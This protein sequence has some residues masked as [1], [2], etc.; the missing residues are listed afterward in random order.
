MAEIMYKGFNQDMTCRDFQYEVGGHYEEDKAELCHSGFHAC[1]YPLDC[2]NYYRP[3]TSEYCTVEMDGLDESKEDDI[4]GGQS[5][6][7][8]KKISIVRKLTLGEMIANSIYYVYTKFKDRFK[9]SKRDSDVC[10]GTFGSSAVVMKG[11][12]SVAACT[13]WSSVAHT[14]RIG[15]VACA[16]ECGSATFTTGI[17]SSAVSTS[18]ESVSLSTGSCSV[19][20]TLS[21]NSVAATGGSN[22]VACTLGSG[23]SARAYGDHSVAV[24]TSDYSYAEAWDKDAVALVLQKCSKARG[25]LGSWLV[26]VDSDMSNIY[27]F[28]VDGKTVLPEVWYALGDN[29][30]LVEVAKEG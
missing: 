23:S 25:V 18:E 8:A 1:E 30:E 29:G 28:R 13:R 9:E 21:P 2:F 20:A 17:Y 15:S 12:R 14:K 11:S 26:F 5:K 22:S 16:T 27:S 4:G 3:S 10:H 6:R 24:S 19:A 7:A